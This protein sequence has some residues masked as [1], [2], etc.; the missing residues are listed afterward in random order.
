MGLGVAIDSLDTIVGS[1]K[2]PIPSDPYSTAAGYLL[3]FANKAISDSITSQ[4]ADD[5]IITASLD[6]KFSPDATCSSSPTGDSFESTGTKAVLMSD[7]IQGSGYV[8]INHVNDYC[9]TADIQPA[10][11]LKA[12]PKVGGLACVDPS[13]AGK[14]LTVTNNYVAYFLQKRQIAPH[15][16]GASIAARDKRDSLQLCKA[17]N[18]SATVA[19][20][21]AR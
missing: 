10:F 17:L 14:Y 1:K 19:T 7:G 9:W 13:Y 2:L 3:D 20:C 21:P 5:K 18:P 11:E 12:T 4:N 8:P 6:L 16:G 15:L